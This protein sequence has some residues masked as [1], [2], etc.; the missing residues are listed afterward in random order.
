MLSAGRVATQQ[1]PLGLMTFNIRTSSI[2]DGSNSWP[3]RKALVARTIERSSPDVVGLQE[4]AREQVEYLESTLTA[5]RWIGVDRGLNGGE[6]LSEYTPIFYRHAELSPIESGNFWLSPTPDA[7]SPELRFTRIVT[8]ARF[9]HRATG[10]Q[11]YVLNTHFSPRAGPQQLDASRIIKERV[12][13]L[14]PGSAVVVLGDFNSTAGES[15][16]WLDLAGGFLRD[17]WTTAGE[18]RGPPA[19]MGGFGP[20]RAGDTGR[21]D[22][23]LV[24]G[25]IHVQSIETVLFNEAGRYPSDHFP[26]A[27]RVEIR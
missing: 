6:G 13:R 12:Q 26:V 23:I 27:A 4:V 25:P 16:V 24:G 19:T 8:W 21:I 18:Q 5:Y 15:P 7:P 22:W 20:P 17:A 1:L 11:F 2:D 14:P 3:H 9:H 10:R